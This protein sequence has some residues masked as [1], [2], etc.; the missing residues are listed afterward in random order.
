MAR[1][2]ELDL[3]TALF[4]AQDDLSGPQLIDDDRAHLLACLYELHTRG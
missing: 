2:P 1:I 3:A 4:G